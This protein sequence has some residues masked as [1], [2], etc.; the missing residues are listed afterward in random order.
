MNLMSLLIVDWYLSLETELLLLINWICTGIFLLM[1]IFLGYLWL[2]AEMKLARHN[3]SKIFN[4]KK[5][6]KK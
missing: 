6:S 5:K 3:E 1:A 4:N 2:R